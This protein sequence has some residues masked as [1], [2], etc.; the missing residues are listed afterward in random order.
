MQVSDAGRICFVRY[1]YCEGHSSPDPRLAEPGQE[2][3]KQMSTPAP[4]TRVAMRRWSGVSTSFVPI[5]RLEV[6]KGGVPGG[7]GRTRHAQR[8]RGVVGSAST[9]GVDG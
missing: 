6:A 7:M 2:V 4:N 9:R 8:G 1:M 3:G 5:F